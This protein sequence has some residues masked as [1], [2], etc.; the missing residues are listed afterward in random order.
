MVPTPLDHPALLKTEFKRLL[1]QIL[2]QYYPTIG[3]CDVNDSSDTDRPIE[4]LTLLMLL[5]LSY[6]LIH[7]SNKKTFDFLEKRL[8]P[9]VKADK[10]WFRECRKNVATIGNDTI[11]PH[12]FNG[13][14]P[15]F[16][17][18][19]EIINFYMSL[20]NKRENEK[21]EIEKKSY[22]FSSFFA[23]KLLFFNNHRYNFQAAARWTKNIT[24]TDYDKLF[25]PIF[26]GECHQSS[27]SYL[28]VCDSPYLH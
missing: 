16:Q 17:L 26:I 21:A 27:E 25:F 15:G 10:W 6:F 1:Q 9:T 23:T 12:S 14:K 4:T 20:G 22:F 11:Q 5:L 18:N 3:S 13:L 19:D 2:P 24:V 8:F 28:E 7:S